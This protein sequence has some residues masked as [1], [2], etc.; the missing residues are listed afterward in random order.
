MI[1][2]APA[3]SRKSNSLI[4]KEALVA[5]ENTHDPE[6]RHLLIRVARQPGPSTEANLTDRQQTQDEKLV[7]IRA[8]G[9]YKEPECVEALKSVMRTEK[10]IA[11]RDS[12]L[13][14]LEEAT[15]KRWPDKREAWQAAEIQPLP[16]TPQSDGFIQRVGAWVPKW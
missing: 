9:K 2:A 15:N 6:A 12:C 4:R 3:S 7:A 13:H 1:R 16:G 14:S 5:L 8:L 11:L 10:D